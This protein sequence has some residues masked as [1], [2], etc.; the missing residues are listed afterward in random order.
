MSAPA[1]KCFP[2]PLSTTPLISAV[3]ARRVLCNSVIVSLFRTFRFFSLLRKRRAT[4]SL[5]SQLIFMLRENYNRFIN[6]IQEIL[7]TFALPCLQSPSRGTSPLL[8]CPSSSC[9]IPRGGIQT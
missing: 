8:F 9:S 2:L 1:Q 6:V 5:V 3:S 4:S 7:P